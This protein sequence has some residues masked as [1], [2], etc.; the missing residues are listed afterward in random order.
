MPACCRET[1]GSSRTTSLS[2]ARPIMVIPPERGTDVP[3]SGAPRTIK[4]DSL[5]V[6]I[7]DT[8][9][10]CLGG[11]QEPYGSYGVSDAMTR[12]TGVS[13]GPRHRE[14]WVVPSMPGKCVVIAPSFVL[15]SAHFR[16]Y[17]GIGS[18]PR[19]AR[20]CI[21]TTR[22]RPPPGY[23]MFRRTGFRPGIRTSTI[24]LPHQSSKIR[25]VRWSPGLDRPP[26]NAHDGYAH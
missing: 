21:A 16:T 14:W 9:M 2:V 1:P 4:I 24:A 7:C 11:C 13:I 19:T 12:W 15:E 23:G 26:S 8:W 25:P 17:D 20:T 18:R 22:R 10:C 3:S 6:D 5:I